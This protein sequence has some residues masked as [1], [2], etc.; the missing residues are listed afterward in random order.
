LRKKIVVKKP[1]SEVVA[2]NIKWKGK[3]TTDFFDEYY[4]IFKSRN[5]NAASHKW[6]AFLLNRSMSFDDETF[7]TMFASFCPVSGSIVYRDDYKRW[8]MTMT[9]AADSKKVRFGYMYFCCW[10]CVCDT[11]DF[12]RYDTKTVTIKGEDGQ[13]VKKEYTFVVEPSPCE[14]ESKLE[15]EW[16][17]PFRGQK[18]T[19]YK[20]AP[21]L[22]CVAGKEKGKKVLDGAFLSDNGYPI[23]GMFH[24]SVEVTDNRYECTDENS[25]EPGRMWQAHDGKGYYHPFC[26]F[27]KMCEDRAKEGYK[28]GMGMIF[29]K[30][31]EIGEYKDKCKEDEEPKESKESEESK[32]SEESEE[33]EESESEEPEKDVCPGKSQSQCRTTKGCVFEPKREC[34][35]EEKSLWA[36]Y[37]GTFASYKKI[38]S[39]KALCKTCGG[40]FKKGKCSKLSEKKVKCKKFK[41]DDSICSAVSG[42]SVAKKGCKGKP[43]FSK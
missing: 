20:S 33:V 21:E 18:T 24:N 23:I 27:K 29:R 32:A 40:K 43:K 8:G 4:N 35:A 19:L 16:T 31:A 25:N 17:E 15:E 1:E 41:K 3:T 5:R 38:C 2:G 14:K 42:C 34:I 36:N 26:E 22:K 13:F 12:I 7:V 6:A 28:S 39:N 11:Q 9:H 10:P 30:V 37:D